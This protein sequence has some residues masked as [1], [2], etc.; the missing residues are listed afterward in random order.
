MK[1]YYS[2]AEIHENQCQV[3]IRFLENPI[4]DIHQII[5]NFKTIDNKY[6]VTYLKEKIRD[7]KKVKAAINCE[8]QQ[9]QNQIENFENL[10]KEIIYEINI[11]NKDIN[12][13]NQEKKK[14]EEELSKIKVLYNKLARLCY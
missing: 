12:E 13:M 11:A 2:E 10:K 3:Q 1:K 5:P 14:L 9:Q 7:L 6:T 4:A 8:N